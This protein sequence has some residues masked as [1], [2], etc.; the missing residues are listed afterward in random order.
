VGV[1]NAFRHSTLAPGDFTDQSDDFGR[2]AVAV[3]D[4]DLRR[5]AAGS[6]DIRDMGR[7]LRL[8]AL[9]AVLWEDTTTTCKRKFWD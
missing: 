6:R 9:S 5:A 8:M 7:F 1:W 2:V 4:L 3:L